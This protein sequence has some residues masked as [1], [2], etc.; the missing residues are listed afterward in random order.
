MCYILDDDRKVCNGNANAAGEGSSDSVG[1][2]LNGKFYEAKP[3][4]S[5][6]VPYAHN[7]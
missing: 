3:D 4:G 1:M 6:F 7:Q 2:W 5:I